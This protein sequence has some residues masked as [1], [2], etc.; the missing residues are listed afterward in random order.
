MTVML[1]KY[2]YLTTASTMRFELYDFKNDCEYSSRKFLQTYINNYLVDFE[3]NEQIEVTDVIFTHIVING[4]GI[5]RT[6][7]CE[8]QDELVVGKEGR[9]FQM[10]LYMQ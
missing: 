9:R 8:S 10:I 3:M 1:L 7:V 5:I 6:R 2:P 4:G